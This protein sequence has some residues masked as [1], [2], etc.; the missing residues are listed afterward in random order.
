MQTGRLKISLIVQDDITIIHA[1]Q[2]KSEEN[3]PEFKLSDPDRPA[4]RSKLV[5]ADI[6]HPEVTKMH[7]KFKN[8]RRRKIS[9]IKRNFQ[10]NVVKKFVSKFTPKDLGEG[11][12][13]IP[14]ESIQ[15]IF[16]D[17]CVADVGKVIDKVTALLDNNFDGMV[18]MGGA[19][20]ENSM[21]RKMIRFVVHKRKLIF[22]SYATLASVRTLVW[23]ALKMLVKGMKQ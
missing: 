11:V 5:L 12:A 22:I 3:C 2:F 15:E 8:N 1:D 19:L 16:V 4:H 6:Y 17:T 20:L 7:V 18:D 9:S 23:Q 14:L 13:K 10:V 21:L